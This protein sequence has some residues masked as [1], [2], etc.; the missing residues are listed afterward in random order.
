MQNDV[1]ENVM[2]LDDVTPIEFRDT[3]EQEFSG[4]LKSLGEPV[5]VDGQRRARALNPLTGK[6]G[7]LLRALADGKFL[8]HGFRN[9]DIRVAL[10]GE[11]STKAEQRRQAAAVTRQLAMLKAHGVIHKLPKTHRYQ[12]SALGRRIV[13]ALLNAH[14]SDVTRLAT[15]A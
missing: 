15:A 3:P 2:I 4:L 11:T 7:R 5:I 1:I 12:L 8:L 13:S 14:A 6:D 9:R 10:H